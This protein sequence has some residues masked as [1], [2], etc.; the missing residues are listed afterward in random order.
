MQQDSALE[1]LAARPQPPG[2]PGD[3]E[4]L[5]FDGLKH[6]VRQDHIC[7]ADGRPVKERHRHLVAEAEH[8]R[9][10]GDHLAAEHAALADQPPD[11]IKGAHDPAGIGPGD[12][13]DRLGK[14]AMLARVHQKREPGTVVIGKVEAV[15][16][17]A[18]RHV[19]GSG[20]QRGRRHAAGTEPVASRVSDQPTDPVIHA[21]HGSRDPHQL[22]PAARASQPGVQPRLQVHVLIGRPR[23]RYS[24]EGIRIRTEVVEQQPPQR[25]FLCPRRIHRL[26]DQPPRQARDVGEFRLP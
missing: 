25:L 6:A 8:L 17:A 13:E 11:L 26:V 10:E 18:A 22:E 20:R 24:R 7:T 5:P 2:V 15:L 12:I 21:P 19:A 1:V 14:R 4:H 23:P 16:H 3:A 9:A